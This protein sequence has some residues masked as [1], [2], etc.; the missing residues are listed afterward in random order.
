M[1]QIIE[2]PLYS[3]TLDPG[4]SR[5]T[6]SPN[7]SFVQMAGSDYSLVEQV[8]GLFHPSVAELVRAALL[9]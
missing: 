7:S 8:C 1:Q 2:D 5:F 6:V 3:L 9:H 4:C